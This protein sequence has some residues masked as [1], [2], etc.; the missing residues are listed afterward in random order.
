MEFIQR[1]YIPILFILFLFFQRISSEPDTFKLLQFSSQQEIR[2]LTPTHFATLKSG[3]LDSMTSSKFTICSSIFVAFFRGSASFFAL[4]LQDQETLWFSLSFENQDKLKEVYTTTLYYFHGAL[5]SNTGEMPP[6]RPHAW[7]HAC[8]TVD[9]ES[10]HVLV[11]I[12]GLLTINDTIS[13]KDFTDNRPSNNLILGIQQLKF[14]GMP[15]L[16]V[17]SEESVS[18]I[19]VFSVPKS[20]TQMVEITSTGLCPDGDV[21]AWS[22]AEWTLAGDAKEVTDEK[23]G[24]T[25]YFPHL[26]KM[27]EGLEM[28]EDCIDLCPR[29][30]A[31]GRLPLPLNL[32]DSSSLV[33][34]VNNPE[35]ATENYWA[36]FRYQTGGNFTDYYTGTP[37]PSDLWVPGQG[38]VSQGQEKHCTVWNGT[39]AEG[40]NL[41]SSNL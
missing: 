3:T 2:N 13:S 35:E 19:N 23:F 14:D 10:G 6:L 20:V 8:T 27:G 33:K 18:N 38:Q 7:S 40:K 16:N 37:F 29:V 39:S 11:V 28:W 21:V 26:Y 24:K 17:Q 1:T 4:R 36:P 34:Q 12:N 31:G 15:N 9:V 5:Y 41:K 25:D 32:E 22:K 30:Q